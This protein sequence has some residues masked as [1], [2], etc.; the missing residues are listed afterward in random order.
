MGIS[1]E[2]SNQLRAKRCAGG[3]PPPHR[4]GEGLARA[5]SECPEHKRE[6]NE[7]VDI[8]GETSNLLFTTLEQ[9]NEILQDTSIVKWGNENE[10]FANSDIP[11][12][13]VKKQAK[14]KSNKASA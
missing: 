6:I 5:I 12:K 9:W 7:M 14:P 4:S 11:P 2:I 1:G 13:V 10:N 8:R 3:S